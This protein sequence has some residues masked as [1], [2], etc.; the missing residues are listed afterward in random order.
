MTC[1]APSVR[2]LVHTGRA[3]ERWGRTRALEATNNVCNDEAKGAARACV[4]AGRRATTP[5]PADAADAKKPHLE[6]LVDLLVLLRILGHLFHPFDL[7]RGQTH[8]HEA[9]AVS[10]PPRNHGASR[11]TSPPHRIGALH[12][13]SRVGHIWVI[14]L[15]IYIFNNI[16][17]FLYFLLQCKF[18]VINLRKKQYRRRAA[19]RGLATRHW[20]GHR[21]AKEEEHADAVVRQALLQLRLRRAA[22]RPSRVS[23]R[24]SLASRAN[25]TAFSRA[26]VLR[27]QR[28]STLISHDECKR[29]AGGAARAG[30]LVIGVRDEHLLSL[31]LPAGARRSMSPTS[32]RLT[33]TTSADALPHALWRSRDTATACLCKSLTDV[34]HAPRP[35][36]RWRAS[37]Q[38]QQR[39][40]QRRGP[41][42]SSAP[43]A[44]RARG[45]RGGRGGARHL[46]RR[47]GDTKHKKAPF[48]CALSSTCCAPQLPALSLLRPPA[49]CPQICA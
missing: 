39:E 2:H 15:C 22:P 24:A 25:L 17:R 12:D 36:W 40:C 48:V 23:W 32:R 28:P 47:S 35:S 8:M 1:R 13:Q 5:C 21:H 11:F 7:L 34:R 19:G 49:S 10:P 26:H 3:R 43:L 16:I 37:R 6:L 9:P 31:G 14:P 41:R 33:K 42:R 27:R 30:H 45:R 29:G 46:H 44:A 38:V 18:V 20:F 4:R